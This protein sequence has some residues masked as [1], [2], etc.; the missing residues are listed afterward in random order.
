MFHSDALLSATLTGLVRFA[1]QPQFDPDTVT[2]GFVG[3]IATFGVAA[4]VILLVIDMVRRIR[5]VNYRAQ[6]R[7]QLERE[8]MTA[9]AA[10]LSDDV[11]VSDDITRGD[12]S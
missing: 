4:I 6:V 2:P 12:R 1:D 5:R 7:E 11:P 8:A 9:D 3:F 10:R